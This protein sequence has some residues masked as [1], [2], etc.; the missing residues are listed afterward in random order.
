MHLG[1]IGSKGLSRESLPPLSE[2]RNSTNGTGW[3]RPSLLGSSMPACLPSGTHVASDFDDARLPEGSRVK[4]DSAPTIEKSSRRSLV[5]A[6]LRPP[7]LNRDY[8]AGA[9]ARN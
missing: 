7:P 5:R 1:G 8:A 4:A 2:S 3:Q 6:C 9:Q